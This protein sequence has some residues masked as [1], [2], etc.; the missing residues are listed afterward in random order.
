MNDNEQ[1]KK[2]RKINK[3]QFVNVKKSGIKSKKKK[4]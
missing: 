2:I 1:L 3:K 4:H